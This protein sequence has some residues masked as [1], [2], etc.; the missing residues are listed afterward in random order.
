MDK[1]YAM[2]AEYFHTFEGKQF[3]PQLLSKPWIC[4]FLTGA[5]FAISIGS[6]LLLRSWLW[7]GLMYFFEVLFLV[8]VFWIDKLQWE[9]QK[10]HFGL[11]TDDPKTHLDEIKLL[12]LKRITHKTPD[13]FATTVKEIAD[14]K[15]TQT[16]FSTPKINIHRLIY[17]PDSK[18]R[19]IAITLSSIALF[20]ALLVNTT[21]IPLVSLL[22]LIAD[23]SFGSYLLKLAGI[24]TGLYF[25]L[26]GVYFG[27]T[28]VKAFSVTWLARWK[29]KA[30]DDFLLQYFV[31]ALIAQYDPLSKK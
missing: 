29:W 6:S 15:A 7:V 3:Y 4:W 2:A 30:A 20:G 31:A 28:Q 12:Y 23:D 19:L 13:S 18:P 11:R 9:K 1:Y 16:R 22:A 25:T 27:F 26:V 24:A 21:E 5:A 14:L 10:K 8:C 17:D